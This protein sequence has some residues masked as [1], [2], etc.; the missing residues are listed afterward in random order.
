MKKMPVE[1]SEIIIHFKN[2]QSSIELKGELSYSYDSKGRVY[3]IYST[4]ATIDADQF[5]RHFMFPSDTVLY[6]EAYT[7][8]I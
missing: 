4:E 3:N 8:V 2:K 1:A 7:E 5:T 6:I